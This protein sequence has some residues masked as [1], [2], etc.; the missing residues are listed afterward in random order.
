MHPT[1]ER[2][3]REANPHAHPALPVVLQDGD[4]RAVVVLAKAWRLRAGVG[5]QVEPVG[6][7]GVVDVYACKGAQGHDGAQRRQ[8]DGR[9]PFHSHE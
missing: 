7:V 5:A 1:D 9:K 3:G 6:R 4:G 8:Q 2:G